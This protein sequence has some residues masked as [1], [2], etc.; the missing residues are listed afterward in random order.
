MSNKKIQNKHL[1]LT[2]VVMALVSSFFLLTGCSVPESLRFKEAD[3]Q[4][5]KSA[6]VIDLTGKTEFPEAVEP[7]SYYYKQLTNPEQKV[8]YNALVAA[9]KNFDDNVTFRVSGEQASTLNGNSLQQI[10]SLVYRDHPELFWMPVLKDDGITIKTLVDKYGGYLN[11]KTPWRMSKDKAEATQ[12]DLDK[13]LDEKA[14]EAKSLKNNY[15]KAKFA[16]RAVVEYLS[17]DEST[18]S[19]QSLY[20][21]F[22][23]HSA[24]CAGYVKLYQVLLNKLGV[25]NAWIPV[26]TKQET[27]QITNNHVVTAIEME[28]NQWYWSDPTWGDAFATSKPQLGLDWSSFSFDQKE[29]DTR[30]TPEV[31]LQD[32]MTTGCCQAPVNNSDKDSYFKH[33]NLWLDSVD[34]AAVDAVLP[35]GIEQAEGGYFMLGMP[36]DLISDFANQFETGGIRMLNPNTH[37]YIN[38]IYTDKNLSGVMVKVE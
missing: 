31:A 8:M 30:Y 9:A 14:K 32:S 26:I 37:R 5:M 21:G 28:S 1:T 3:L 4:D 25:P 23:T 11:I 19:D 7:S 13:W 36:R 27:A 10:Y 6:G 12:K 29:F 33:E 22:T 38:Q 16:Y 17:Y 20:T 24:V 15:D 34:Q 2:M 35:H 18:I